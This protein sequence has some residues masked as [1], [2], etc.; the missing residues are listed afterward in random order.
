MALSPDGKLLAT[1]GGDKLVKLWELPAGTEV[2]KLEAHATQ[3]LGLSFHPDGSQ[4]VSAGAD[5]TLKVWDVK[6]RENTIALGAATSSFNAVA[7]SPV[8]PAVLAVND[9]GA[10]L[11]YTDLKVHSGAQSSDAASEREWGRAESPLFCVSAASRGGRVFAGSSAGRLM[12]WDQD[13]KLI[14]NLDVAAAAAPPV[15]AAP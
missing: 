8:G 13:G 4:L 15:A 5:R 10:L 6:T 12:S 9:A 11:R 14:D 7:W 1:A 2:A 3:V